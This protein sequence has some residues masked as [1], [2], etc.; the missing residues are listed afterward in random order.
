MNNNNNQTTRLPSNEPDR[1][2]CI[3]GIIRKHLTTEPWKQVAI[4]DG[5][6]VDYATRISIKDS[7]KGY[8][9]DVYIVSY[10]IPNEPDYDRVVL[11][12]PRDCS[13][14]PAMH[15]ARMQAAMLSLLNKHMLPVPRLLAETENYVIE[16]F[17]ESCDLS[18]IYTTPL[19]MPTHAI[20]SV[21]N[22]VGE[23]LRQFHCVPRPSS[24]TGYGE[25]INE[26]F[27]GALPDWLTFFD[28]DIPNQIASCQSRGLFDL[29]LHGL[30]SQDE[31]AITL[32][33]YFESVKEYLKK[34][35]RPC[36]VHADMCSGNIRVKT[37]EE[38][39]NNQSVT[40]V[41]IIDFADCLAGDGLYDIGRILSHCYGDWRFVEAIEERYCNNSVD[42]GRC[43]AFTEEQKAMI[44]FYAFSFCIWL[45][46]M[47]GDD[48]ESVQKYNR[49][50]KNL[51]ILGQS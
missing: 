30:S 43:G 48:Q 37:K 39:D 16:S 12:L 3:I 26:Q 40:V 27:Q 38:E 31:A 7:S 11:R 33:K 46:D 13:E 47:L 22:R 17:I 2:N 23:I 50:L 21:F 34:F 5:D 35:D 19:D 15:T 8:D 28:R 44:K 51:K 25:L 20:K 9:N 32:T 36:I 14:G 10:G 29:A 4:N 41:G 45:M 42:D 18:D 6:N 49:I 1:S 24:A